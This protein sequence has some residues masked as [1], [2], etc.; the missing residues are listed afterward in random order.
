M[1]TGP[2]DFMDE[3]RLWSLH[4]MSR[5]AWKRYGKGGSWF[6]EVVRPGFKCNM[7]DIQAAIGLHQLKRL[8]SMQT[9]R[10]EVVAAY[11]ELLGDIPEVQLPVEQ[12]GVSSARHLY[13][14]RL[15]LD[16]L[17]IDRSAFIDEMAARNIGTSV[18]FIPIHLHPYYRERYGFA[19]DDFPIAWREYQRLVSLPLNPRLSEQDVVDVA[20]AVRAIVNAH[21]G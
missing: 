16:R 17:R 19:E 6:Y 21:R 12:P 2:D 7:T 14:I 11:G 20:D 10:G 18:H 15:H 4:G 3:A 13:P 1:L 8:E 5:D 9:R